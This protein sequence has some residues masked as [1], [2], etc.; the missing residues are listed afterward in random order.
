M[1][2]YMLKKKLPN[3]FP[4][5]PEGF[6]DKIDEALSGL[7]FAC[8]APKMKPRWRPAGIA[9]LAASVLIILSVCLLMVRPV[10]AANI[11]AV[12]DIV[13]ALSPVKTP[14]AEMQQ[15]IADTAQR[16]LSLFFSGSMENIGQRF[17]SG[18][19]WALNDDTLLAAYYLQF[20][21]ATL[22]LLSDGKTPDVCD[23]RVTDIQAAQ[24]AFRYTADARY[25]LTL[26]GK[27]V[28]TETVRLE[29]E[30]TSDG[31]RI[32]AMSMDG[33]DFED[34][35]QSVMQYQSVN[36]GAVLS[37]EIVH[38]N[39]WLIAQAVAEH[40]A[41]EAALQRGDVLSEE[42]QIEEIAAELRY[43]YYLTQKTCEMPDLSALIERNEDTEQFFLALDLQI[44]MAE[45]RMISKPPA[46]EKGYAEILALEKDSN[47]IKATVYVKTII[48]GSV[49]ETIG[50]SIRPIDN[51][52]IVIG[53]ENCDNDGIDA[54]LVSMA[55]Q[56]MSDGCT[57][58]EA[59][60]KA[61]QK[62]LERIEWISAAI[63]GY[64]EQG[65]PQDDAS[66]KALMDWFNTQNPG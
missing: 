60:S 38:Y 23:I 39:A 9:A 41:K 62:A 10:L 27:A 31:L 51:G 63:R 43:Q 7:G 22:A 33:A 61:Y 14:E 21:G 15:S 52:Y 29:L 5:T 58:T 50:L 24:K 8:E 46:V 64:M 53:Y 1:R 30:E 48:N 28:K 16:V 65:F 66:S 40:D 20:E 35:R 54:S 26:G 2:G 19:E 57:R 3:A 47:T 25:E 45:G 56:Y 36:Q 13:C 44:R 18:E 17:K 55:A 49:G 4:E 34:Y 6:T 11:P 12:S 59:Y 37:E 42:E 32:V